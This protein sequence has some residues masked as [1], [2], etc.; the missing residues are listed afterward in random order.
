[1]T[2]W[3]GNYTPNCNYSWQ[4]LSVTPKLVF[5]LIQGF[6]LFQTRNCHLPLPN[7][8]S[9]EG[10]RSICEFAYRYCSYSEFIFQYFPDC[11]N[12]YA[13]IL[14]AEW[15]KFSYYCALLADS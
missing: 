14:A 8:Y 11:L 4:S 13:A 2:V 10:R 9:L 3:W 12:D 5:L 6:D 7:P 1:M 15:S